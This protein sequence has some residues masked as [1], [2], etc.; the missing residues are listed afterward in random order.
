MQDAVGGLDDLR[1]LQ[2]YDPA[3][4]STAALKCVC[5]RRTLCRLRHMYPYLFPKS[6]TRSPFADAICQSC[7]LDLEPSPTH[8]PQTSHPSGRSPRLPAAQPARPPTGPAAAI[9]AAAPEVRRFVSK[10]DWQPFGEAEHLERIS[11]FELCGLPFLALPV[12]HGADYMCFGYGFGPEDARVVYLS[13]YTALVPSTDALLSEW[14]ARGCIELLVLDALHDSGP[15]PV[16]A[17]AE[18]SVAL[19][20]RLRPRRTLLVGMGHGMEHVATNKRLRGLKRQ[21]GIDIQLASDGQFVPLRL[22]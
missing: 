9:Q 11:H 21:E 20:R 17:S 10:I 1:S 15:H 12:Q 3:N 7:E 22:F 13:D 16:H 18:E 4:A 2:R 6:A 14:A 5:D 19:A 8:L